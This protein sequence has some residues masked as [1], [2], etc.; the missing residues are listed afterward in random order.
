MTMISVNVS[1]IENKVSSILIT[2]H[3][4]QNDYGKD[5]VCAGVSTI[6]YGS[7][8]ALDIHQK[9]NFKFD[10]KDGYTLIEI[11]SN[12]DQIQLM[13]DMMLIQ[14]KTL[15]E[16]YPKFIQIKQTHGGV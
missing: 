12:N 2:G 1:F 6:V 14:L 8:N 15:E 9:S 11:L 5:I 13:L 16:A 3:A 4:N 7:I 10:L